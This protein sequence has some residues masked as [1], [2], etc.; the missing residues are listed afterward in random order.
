MVSFSCL[1]CNE[2]FKKSQ[3]AG[4]SSRC[5]APLSCLDCGT[6]FQGGSFAAHTSCISEAQKYQ[7]SLYRPGGKAAKLSPQDAWMA[8][9]LKAV[10]DAESAPANIREHLVRLGELTNIPR[11][12]KK[13]RNFVANSLKL[14]H[15]SLVGQ[16]WAHL[17]KTKN[18][19]STSP[20]NGDASP[21]VEGRSKKRPR[22]PTEE[23][24]KDEAPIVASKKIQKTIRAILKGAPGREMTV[25]SLCKEATS[26]LQAETEEQQSQKKAI[27]G[28]VR[29]VLQAGIKKVEMDGKLARYTPSSVNG[30]S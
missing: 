16:I 2:S 28:Q 3:A 23:E 18:E 10:E 25:K 21:A 5:R 15:D 29:E 7:K 8:V 4:H 24:K 22:S 27:K 1:A 17:V 14:R 11:Q 12:E 30:H 6:T 26:Q 20:L 13:F 19:H 9:V